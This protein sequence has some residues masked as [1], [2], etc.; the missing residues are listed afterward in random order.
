MVYLITRLKVNP[1]YYG[2]FIDLVSNPD[3]IASNDWM[4]NEV[5][6]ILKKTTVA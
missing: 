6:R 5:V 3:Y 1:E 2:L 4:N